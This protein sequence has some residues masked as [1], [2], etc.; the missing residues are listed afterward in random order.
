[1]F[2]VAALLPLTYLYHLYKR[3]PLSLR[4][5]LPLSSTGPLE[6]ETT[7][8]YGRRATFLL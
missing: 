8:F 5:S 2:S 3:L 1:M 4:L 7:L 6:T